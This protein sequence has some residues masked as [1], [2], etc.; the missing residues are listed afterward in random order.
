M[1]QLNFPENI[2]YSF[3]KISD[4]NIDE[5]YGSFFKR[6]EIL[7]AHINRKKEFLAG[8]LAAKEVIKMCGLDGEL[9]RENTIPVWPKRMS[10]SLTHN[11]K[12]A[13]AVGSVDYPFIG[14]DLEKVILEEK[15]A[16]IEKQV[17]TNRDIRIKD[18]M[19]TQEL[20]TLIFS[21]KEAFYKFL[22][23]K[24]E[25]YFGFSEASVI[26]LDLKSQSGTLLLHSNKNNFFKFNNRYQFQFGRFFDSIYCLFYERN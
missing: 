15:I 4:I 11:K 2:F 14:I 16:V 10:G 8:R 24:V 9:E 22:Y 18:S 5:S 19:T 26:E 3:K 21:A 23:P 1:Q 25:T 17:L 20:Y 7:H 13:F 6:N 12:W